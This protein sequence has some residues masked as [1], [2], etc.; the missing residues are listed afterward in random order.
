MDLVFNNLQ[1][2]VEKTQ[3]V[4]WD[5]LHDYGRIECKQT[6]EDLEKALDVAYQDIL[7]EFDKTWGVKNVIV[8]HSNLVVT[9]M[10]RPQINIIYRFSLGP[11]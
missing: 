8:T 11:R 7:N 2:P 4:A 5:T 1:W 6:L 10:D 3:Q 9:W